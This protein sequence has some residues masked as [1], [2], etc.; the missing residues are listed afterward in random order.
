[1][2]NRENAGKN[3]KTVLII[4]IALLLVLAL[5]LGGFTFASYISKGSGTDSA[6]VA[7]W[8]FTVGVD[9][10]NVFGTDYSLEESSVQIVGDG[11]GVAVSAAEGAGN[12]VA[13]GTSGSLTFEITGDAEVA[14][15]IAVS[16]QDS[17]DIA[18]NATASETTY[19]Y[20]PVKYTLTKY[21]SSENRASNTSGTPV[22]SQASFT[23]L[24]S[25]VEALSADY[26]APLGNAD[27][28]AYANAGYYTLTWEWVFDNTANVTKSGTGGDLTGNECDTIL[29]MY[30][31]AG[32][33]G[34]VTYN[35]ATY[36]I[37]GGTSTTLKL[38]LS[39]TVEQ[40][41]TNE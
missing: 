10:S 5:T 33:S 25:K 41:Q 3:K 8:G 24:K 26:I 32:N 19:T 7:K 39:I 9:A 30:S 28:V 37:N 29:A 34:T 4:A 13:P 31:D 38:A 17:T 1:M 6:T 35:G 22:V 20:N 21:T 40:I 18:L 23:E 27:Y 12:V 36:T 16:M 15:K 11:E 2:Q 14:A